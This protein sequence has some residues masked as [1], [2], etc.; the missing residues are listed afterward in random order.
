MRHGHDIICRRKAMNR[1]QDK[2][3]LIDLGAVS[4]ETRGGPFGTEDSR[5][6]LMNG[7]AGLAAD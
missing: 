3:E 2:H 7:D 6:T 1:E 4:T 5:G